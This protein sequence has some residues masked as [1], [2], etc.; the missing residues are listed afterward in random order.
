MI[1]VAIIGFLAA[2]AV[3]SFARFQSRTKQSEAKTMLRTMFTV[4]RS[5]FSDHDGFVTAGDTVGFA[6]EA[7]NRYFYRLDNGCASTWSR[8]GPTP[9]TGYDCISQDTT[10]YP[11]TLAAPAP[12]VAL[13]N[14]APSVAG[15]AGTCP[16][17]GF[18]G[19]AVGNIDTDA[20]T[21]QWIISTG[22]GTPGINSCNLEGELAAGVPYL[23]NSDAQCD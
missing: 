9:S 23:I 13:S 22:S 11:G 4:Q 21:D 14:F 16:A 6:F 10:R 8:P 17:C 2:I 18:S 19:T 1:V 7:S 12:I 20:V 3:P 5:W 15:V